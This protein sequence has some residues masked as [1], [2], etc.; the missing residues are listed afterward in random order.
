MT[1]ESRFRLLSSIAT[2]KRFQTEKNQSTP[3][4]QAPFPV[5]ISQPYVVL[6]NH[7]WYGHKADRKKLWYIYPFWYNTGVWRTDKRR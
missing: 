1:S 4:W 5:R 7:I 3:E 6:E 2:V